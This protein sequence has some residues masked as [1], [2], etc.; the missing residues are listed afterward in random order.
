[1]AALE[2]WPIVAIT[3]AC[4]HGQIDKYLR[5]R[6]TNPTWCR[7]L[8][9]KALQDFPVASNTK[10]ELLAWLRHLVRNLA[11]QLKHN[12]AQSRDWQRIIA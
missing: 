4:W 10:Q 9:E 11:D 3:C 5:I 8:L 1:M 7:K 12:R 2:C 6:L